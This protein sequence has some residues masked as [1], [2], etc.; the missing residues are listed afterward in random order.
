MPNAVTA[1]RLGFAAGLLWLA[2]AAGAVPIVSTWSAGSGNW[3]DAANWSA[4]VPNT[5]AFQATVNNGGTAKLDVSVTIDS[6]VVGLGTVQLND[7]KSLDLV[8]NSSNGAS[9]LIQIAAPGNADISMGSSSVL[10][11][12]GALRASGGGALRF[13]LGTIDNTGGGSLQALDGSRLQ[14]GGNV[15]KG[16]S[17]TTAGSGVVEL[18][19][20]VTFSGVTNSGRLRI[21]DTHS[22]NLLSDSA[23]GSTGVIEMSSPGGTAYVDMIGR[24]L[25]NQGILQAS[26]G[27]A[28]RFIAGTIDNTG[29]GTLRALDDSHLLLGGTTVLGGTLST[30]GTGVIDIAFPTNFDGAT[31]NGR[32]RIADGHSLTFTGDSTN[33]ATGTIEI[34]GGGSY[35]IGKAGAVLSNKGV[36]QADGGGILSIT[37]ASID[38]TGGSIRALNGSTVL[39]GGDLIVG[40]TLSTAGTGVINV[41]NPV[42]FRSVTNSGH[43]MVSDSGY[44]TWVDNTTNSATGVIDAAPFSTGSGQLGASTVLSNQGVLQALGGTQF[45]LLTNS[46]S[47]VDNL[48]GGSIR[49]LDGSKLQ[50]SGEGEVRNAGG[51]LEVASG[52][53]ML[54][55]DTVKLVQ[56]AGKMVVDGLLSAFQTITML[57]G[58]LEG[59]GMIVGNVD[60][61]G[62][63]MAPG[64]GDYLVVVGNYRQG[65]G[66]ILDIDIGGLT[67]RFGYD[68]LSA[69]AADLAGELD[70][71]LIDGFDLNADA[72]FDILLGAISGKFDALVLPAA[73]GTWDIEYLEDRVRLVFDFDP[74]LPPPV[75]TGVSEPGSLALLAL[76]LLAVGRMRRHRPH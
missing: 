32:V 22:L 60:N 1:A 67:P 41:Q 17:L 66:G 47:R 50:F 36:V 62:G 64:N 31:N 55:G 63:R 49:A 44:A 75:P 40:G 30:T 4:G 7:A 3:S 70:V 13:H 25:S 35:V 34:L 2:S 52:G 23:N 58:R 54:L 76:G 24:T 72:Q 74:T 28:L 37:T 33:G 51:L 42:T 10:S 21:A 5:A 14:L 39:L 73:R 53:F 48:A 9:G 26:G 65:K 12:A 61:L 27:G 59:K 57:G 20:D 11:N 71:R 68:V 56:T 15:I 46:T 16:G 8:G 45:N 18:L 6:L 29:G 19:A 38:N 43:L 69:D